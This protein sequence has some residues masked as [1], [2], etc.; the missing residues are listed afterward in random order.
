M[1]DRFTEQA[2]QVIFFARYEASSLGSESIETEHLLLGVVRQDKLLAL[3][4][5]A[6]QERQFAAQSNRAY[7]VPGLRYQNPSTCR[8]ALLLNGSW[9]IARRKRRG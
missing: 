6:V 3:R 5:P 2:R 1:F 8:S 9:L 4:L 7:R